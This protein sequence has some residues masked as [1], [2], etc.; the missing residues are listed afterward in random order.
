MLSN[1]GAAKYINASTVALV[2]TLV[3]IYL[4]RDH[5]F[6]NQPLA[7]LGGHLVFPI[8]SWYLA[9]ILLYQIFIYLYRRLKKANLALWLSSILY[10]IFLIMIESAA[11]HLFDIKNLGTASYSGLPLCDCLHAP[12]WMQLGY[13]VLGPAYLI[14]IVHWSKKKSVPVGTPRE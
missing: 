7:S 5:Y 8:I 1:T 13:F 10:W 11:Y 14:M 9:L 4:T 2:L 12:W 6:Y 3:W